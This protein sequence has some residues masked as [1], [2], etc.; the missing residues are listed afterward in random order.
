MNADQSTTQRC[1]FT[2]ADP[3]CTYVYHIA[4]PNINAPG[5]SFVDVEPDGGYY[6][7]C[8]LCYCKKSFSLF[9][10]PSQPVFH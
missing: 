5:A 6:N 8:L 9:L 7:A 2:T 1:T 10:S 3:F 4:L